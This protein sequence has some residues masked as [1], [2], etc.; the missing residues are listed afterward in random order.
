MS[1]VMWL[2]PVNRMSLRPGL[3]WLTLNLALIIQCLSQ[4]F[5]SIL[6]PPSD[7]FAYFNICTINYPTLTK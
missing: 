7:V 4:I 1:S 2:W 6:R 3:H 5:F